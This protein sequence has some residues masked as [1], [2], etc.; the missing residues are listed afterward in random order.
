[1]KDAKEI[2]YELVGVDGIEVLFTQERIDR[3]TVPNGLYC[4]D[5]RETEGF[6]GIA[7]TLEPE[8]WINYWGTVLSIQEF[9]LDECGDYQLIQDD[10]DY[11]NVGYTLEEYLC[12]KFN[13]EEQQPRDMEMK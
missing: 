11:L 5:V 3:K 7:A 4:Y 2:Y 1:M 10:I 9:P 6:S 12:E 13:L 8:V